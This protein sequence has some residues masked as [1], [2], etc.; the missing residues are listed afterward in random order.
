MKVWCDAS[1]LPKEED[2]GVGVYFVTDEGPKTFGVFFG[3]AKSIQVAEL[4]GIRLSILFAR[5]YTEELI[6]IYCDCASIVGMIKRDQHNDEAFVEIRKLMTESNVKV[7]WQ[8]RRTSD[9]ARIV[10]SVAE[11]ARIMKRRIRIV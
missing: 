4:E 3:G 6:E 10:D 9:E 1:M 7:Y 8:K 2:A 11:C 5:K